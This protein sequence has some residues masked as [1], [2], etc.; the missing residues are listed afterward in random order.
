MK[1][2]EYVDKASQSDSK[3]FRSAKTLVLETELKF[4]EKNN[5]NFFSK[6]IT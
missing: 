1:A 2:R 5:Q 3:T 4:Y 6:N